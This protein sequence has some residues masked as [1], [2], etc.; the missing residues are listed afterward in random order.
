M[1]KPASNT[2]EFSLQPSALILLDHAGQSAAATDAARQLIDEAMAVGALIGAVRTPEENADAAKAQLALKSVRKQIE[3]AYRAAKDPLVKLGRACDQTFQALVLEIDREDG[4]IGQLA[5]AFALAERRR[6]AAENELAKAQMAKL[7]TEKHAAI[8]ATSDPVK[9]SQVLEDF[10]RRAAVE[11]PPPS[12][13]TRAP[14]QKIREDWDINVQ[15]IIETAKWALMTSRWDVLHIEIRLGV[16]KELLNGGMTAIPGLD[17]KRV[18][19]AG[20]VLPPAQK[21]IDV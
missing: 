6:V 7:E 10:S 12:A 17:C 18:A 3:S 2:S 1:L 15:N 4:R 5:G 8:A 20:V 11:V 9:Q 21:A 14:G 19:K 16:V 13:P